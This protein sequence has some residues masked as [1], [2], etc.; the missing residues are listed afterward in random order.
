MRSF[1]HAEGV[2]LIFFLDRALVRPGRFDRHIGNVCGF[3]V[4]FLTNAHL[5]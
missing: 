2:I 4:L 3:D 1:V 5:H